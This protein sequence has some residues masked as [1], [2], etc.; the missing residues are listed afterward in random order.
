MNIS[1]SRHSN[2]NFAHR[3]VIYWSLFKVLIEHLHNNSHQ[4][5]TIHHKLILFAKLVRQWKLK[6]WAQ[7]ELECLI[8][9]SNSKFKIAYRNEALNVGTSGLIQ[10]RNRL[11]VLTLHSPFCLFDRKKKY[12]NWM[13]S[14]NTLESTTLDEP[15][16]CASKWLIFASQCKI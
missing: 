6:E 11:K 12:P 4:R 7:F 3:V 5:E 15:I 9:Y 13:V 8:I 16:R 14:M 1:S 2:S 10:K